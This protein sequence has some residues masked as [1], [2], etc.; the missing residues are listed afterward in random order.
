MVTPQD[1]QLSMQGKMDGKLDANT[2]GEERE[3]MCKLIEWIGS[4]Q[5]LPCSDGELYRRF[6]NQQQFTA[7]EGYACPPAK[8]RSTGYLVYSE[9]GGL[10]PSDPITGTTIETS[11]GNASEPNTRCTDPEDRP[12]LDPRADLRT[13]K[14]PL[15]IFDE[16]Q[17]APPAKP[18]PMD[19]KKAL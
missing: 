10:M 16:I 7:Y 15:H 2:K 17:E 18:E 13:S 14:Q 12:N 8:V 5:D 1:S 9:Q 11:K 19:Y 4:L 3:E 6:V